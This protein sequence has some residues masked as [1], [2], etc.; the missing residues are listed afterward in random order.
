MT[1]SEKNFVTS[2]C[3][4]GIMIAHP[5]MDEDEQIQKAV[6]MADKI[7]KSNQLPDSEEKTNA[8]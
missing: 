1:C 4:Y 6:R 2:Q 5:E 7:I 3:V 8:T